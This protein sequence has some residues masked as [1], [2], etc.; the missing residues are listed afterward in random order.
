MNDGL[1]ERLSQCE[2]L[3]EALFDALN[4][5]LESKDSLILARSQYATLLQYLTVVEEKLVSANIHQVA[6]VPPL[7]EGETPHL[8]LTMS[9]Y[10]V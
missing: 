10:N 2:N 8:Q 3:T 6:T 1:V 9:R 4:G 5:T 7:G